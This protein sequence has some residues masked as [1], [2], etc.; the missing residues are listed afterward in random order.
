MLF[1]LSPAKRLDF[2]TPLPPLPPA[3]PAPFEGVWG[4]GAQLMGL[5]RQRARLADFDL[6]GRAFAAPASNRARMVFRREA[7]R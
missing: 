5:L 6:E 4:P 1:L 2:Q 7:P 3:T